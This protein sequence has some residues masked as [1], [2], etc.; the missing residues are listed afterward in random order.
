MHTNHAYAQT[1]STK[2]RVCIGSHV[3]Q[4]HKL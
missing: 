3:N 4:V 2:E 1:E